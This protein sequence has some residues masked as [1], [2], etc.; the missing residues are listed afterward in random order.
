M[1][2]SLKRLFEIRE[3]IDNIYDDI[4][5]DYSLNVSIDDRRTAF[6]LTE[7]D[8]L[9][10]TLRLIEHKGYKEALILIRS[11]F[12]KFFYFW[13]M[14][15]GKKY[16]W[17]MQ[18]YIQRS[19]SATD[20]EAR[21][22]TLAKWQSGKKSGD[23]L[24]AEVIDIQP[25]REEN[26]IVVNYEW[27]GLSVTKNDKPTGELVPIY[28]FMLYE[29]DSNVRFLTGLSNIME[30]EK[31]SDIRKKEEQ[32]Q[33]MI[34]HQ[35]INFDNILR[36]LLLNE[37]IDENQKEMIL[38]HYNFLSS[39]VHTGKESIELWRNYSSSD[40]YPAPKIDE[41]VISELV[42]LYVAK[43]MHLY[44]KTMISHYKIKNPNF[45]STKYESLVAEL[46]TFSKDFWFIDNEPSEFDK[47]NSDYRKSMRDMMAGKKKSDTIETLYY[48]NPLTRLNDMRKEC[49]YHDK[50]SKL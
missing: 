9:M 24:Y 44:L 14:L 27:T 33:K 34:Y 21:D 36:N 35:F 48:E 2:G 1:D 28:N 25:G 49:N 38:V 20:R 15:E 43:L 11:S 19:T 31:F 7:F 45:D 29:Y 26:V 39:Y 23:P 22:N 37:L 12:E 40:K 4:L 16:R 8:T 30:G 50:N 6:L 18:Y 10:Q 17:T 3:N 46:D 47:K 41:G 13:L 5:Q 32:K 42:F